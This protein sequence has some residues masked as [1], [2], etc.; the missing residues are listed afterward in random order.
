MSNR[1][2]ERADFLAEIITTAIESNAIQ[3]WARVSDYKWGSERGEHKLGERH[4]ASA[5]LQPAEGIESWADIAAEG[6]PKRIGTDKRAPLDV[7]AIAAGIGRIMRRKVKVCDQSR[8]TIIEASRENDGGDIDA[9]LADI[10]VQAAMLGE[11]VF[12]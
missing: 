7:D 2:A 3:Y 8:R 4:T 5:Q 12:G 9:E 1:T 11:I 6:L 10:I